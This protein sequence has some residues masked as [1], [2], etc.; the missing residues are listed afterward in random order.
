VVILIL[1]ILVSCFGFGTQLVETMQVM[2]R[3]PVMCDV[4]GVLFC[5]WC[6]AAVYQITSHITSSLY[7]QIMP[8]L[9]RFNCV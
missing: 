9:S 8:P 1:H 3:L 6:C 2:L 4:L 5:L 7:Y